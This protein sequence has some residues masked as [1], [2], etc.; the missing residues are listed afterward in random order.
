MPRWFDLHDGTPFWLRRDG[1]A[2]VHDPLRTN[3][4]GA[5]VVVLDRRDAAAKSTSLL[6]HLTK[7]IGREQAET[8]YR[9]CARGIDLV[10]RATQ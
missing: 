9:E 8:A 2:A 5:D 1:L 3:E 4:R 10:E 7:A 6:I